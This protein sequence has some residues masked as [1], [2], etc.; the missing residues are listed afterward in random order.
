MCG[1]SFKEAVGRN[2]RLTQ[3]AGQSDGDAIVSMSHAVREQRACKVLVLN[4]RGGHEAAPFWN[5]LSINPVHHQGRLMLYMVRAADF[6]I[7]LF[8]LAHRLP[9]HRA[10]PSPP[11]ASAS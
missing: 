11:Q 3:C 9:R 8:R 4:F 10:L 2:P 7:P 1:Y 5:M 6:S